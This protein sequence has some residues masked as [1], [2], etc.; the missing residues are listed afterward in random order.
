MRKRNAGSWQ[1]TVGKEE[2]MIPRRQR[3]LGSG[4]VLPSTGKLRFGGF[5]AL[6]PGTR[7]GKEALMGAIPFQ[8][9]EIEYPTSD[10][11]PLAESE[12]HYDV[13]SELVSALRRRYRDVPDVWVGANM[14]LCYE[15]GNPRAVI[16][17][18][19]IMAKGIG[20]HKR[21]NYLLWQERPPSLI[22]EVSSRSTRLEDLKKKKEIYQ[23]IGV[24][25]YILYDPRAEYL[26]PPLQGFRLV[27][28]QYRPLV[29]APDGSILSLVTGL[30]L[31]REGNLLRLIDA[32]TGESLL[33]TPEQDVALEEKDLVLQQKERELQEKDR[34][35]QE[36]NASL[37][38]K[39]RALQA[40]EEEIARL[41]RELR[42][43]S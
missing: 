17:P 18:D 3:M 29:P 8:R 5:C 27:E 11:Q 24:E 33:W 21:D 39:D 32:M 14:F 31:H 20:K 1:R 30:R 22:V 35:L 37:Q 43:R 19:V 34:I 13:I 12:I 26:K 7:R 36:R 25:E 40:A 15:E 38:E 4:S 2:G 42:G 41:R 9:E 10:G 23:R 16:A 6:I 28:E